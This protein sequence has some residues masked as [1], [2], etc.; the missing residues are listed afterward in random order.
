MSLIEKYTVMHFSQYLLRLGFQVQ[1]IYKWEKVILIQKLYFIIELENAVQGIRLKVSKLSEPDLIQPYIRSVLRAAN[2][3]LPERV[4]FDAGTHLYNGFNETEI[5]NSISSSAKPLFYARHMP[6]VNFNSSSVYP[7]MI[8]LIRHPVDRFISHFN[9]RRNGDNLKP[10]ADDDKFNLRK[11]VSYA[12]TYAALL[13]IFQT[14]DECISNPNKYKECHEN[15][16]IYMLP[17]FCGQE[18]YCKKSNQE[19]FER[20]KGEGYTYSTAC[21]KATLTRGIL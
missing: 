16:L 10:T 3:V 2:L 5:I 19:A 20:A 17:F 14:I 12:Y 8:N 15:Q 6:Y 1:L 18:T 11:Y 9:Y 4:R 13:I 21:I 7:A